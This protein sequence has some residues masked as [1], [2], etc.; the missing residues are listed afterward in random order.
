MK[1]SFFILFGVCAFLQS[2]AQQYEHRIN[3]NNQNQVQHP[4]AEIDSI[5]YTGDNEN[6]QKLV[7]LSDGT[8]L[9]YLIMDI[10]TGAFVNPNPD[11]PQTCPGQPTVTDFNGNVYNTVVIGNQ[12]WTVENLRASNYNNGD[13]IP[14]VTAN[15]AWQNLSSGA[16]SHYNNDALFENPYGKLYNWFAVADDRNVCPAGWHVP[17]DDDW[18]EMEISLGMSPA[19]ADEMFW[20][21]GDEEVG[22]KL[23]STGTDYWFVPNLNATNESGFSALPGGYRTDAGSFDLISS[24][25]NFWSAT[26]QI[27]THSWR[28]QLNVAGSGVN[29]NINNKKSGKSVRCVRD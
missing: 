8:V 27:V 28:R 12:C 23:K 16:W 20:R 5:K 14:N 3:F 6:A 22:S 4:I 17:T 19:E 29:R 21:G 26:E 13:E 15:S 1:K 9:S 18:K 10:E 24:D 11:G 2:N 25:A 7:Y